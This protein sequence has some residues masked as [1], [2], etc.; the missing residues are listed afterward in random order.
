MTTYTIP[1]KL[2]ALVPEMLEHFQATPP[3]ANVL[4]LVIAIFVIGQEAPGRTHVPSCM[5]VRLTEPIVV[6]PLLQV[7][8][9][10]GHAAG[11]KERKKE[12]KKES[13]IKR[14][15]KRVT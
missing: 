2:G 12:R 8:Q 15:K 13:K 10:A 7:T 4:L 14:K 6:I 9:P 1:Y 5:L 11:E 3:L